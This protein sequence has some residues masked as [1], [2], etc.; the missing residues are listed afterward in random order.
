MCESPAATSSLLS[1]ILK[2]GALTREDPELNAAQTTPL[3]GSSGSGSREGLGGGAGDGGK[4][5]G[6]A[7]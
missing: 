6:H 2:P 4:E 5:V 1:G 7:Q 3:R